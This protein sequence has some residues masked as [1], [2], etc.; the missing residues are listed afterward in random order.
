VE[1]LL[2]FPYGIYRGSFL[3]IDCEEGVRGKLFRSKDVHFAP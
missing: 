2:P 3:Q 1:Y